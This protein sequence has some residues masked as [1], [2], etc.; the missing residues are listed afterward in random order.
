M[1]RALPKKIKRT[2]RNSLKK[3]S[4]IVIRET[5]QACCLMAVIFSVAFTMITTYNFIV[6]S[7]YF[8]IRKTLVRGCKKL[9][10]KEVLSLAAVKP[11]QT[12]LTVNR[13]AIVRRIKANPW[14][15]EVSI[16]VELPDRLVIDVRERTAIAIVKHDNGLYLLDHSGRLFKKFEKTD[17]A[18]L[19]VL[20]GFF[21]G[22]KTN[23]EFLEKAIGLM[24]HIAPHSGFIDIE[25]V[26][27]I[28]CDEA[29]GLSLYTDGGLCLRLGT[30]GYENKLKR[31]AAVMADLENRNY[32]SEFMQIDLRNPNKIFVAPKNVSKPKCPMESTK[33]YQT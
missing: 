31:L 11:T 1:K 19:P 14:V 5:F 17:E 33:R 16:G 7:P 13:Q 27:E 18:D 6:S 2:R 4:Q 3:R 8:M 26:S 15:R 9:T 30:D 28:H 29:V 22:G 20:T 12:V 24:T 21:A 25:N 23:K 32:K 10:E